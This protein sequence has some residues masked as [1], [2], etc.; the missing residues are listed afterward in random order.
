MH[1]H[2]HL[3]LWK[4]KG[5]SLSYCNPSYI[6]K[7]PPN[8]KYSEGIFILYSIDYLIVTVNGLRTC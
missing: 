7:C 4:K 8:R 1:C 5:T 2:G 3:I 6:K